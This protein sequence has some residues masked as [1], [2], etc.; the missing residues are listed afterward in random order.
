MERQEIVNKL[1]EIFRQ[2]FEN[3][4]LVLEESM[5][6]D[7]VDNWASLTHM[8][9]A[10]AVQEEFGITFSIMDQI[11]LMRVGDIISLIESKTA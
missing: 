6:P 3:E 7:D 5:T 4:N 8:Q 1:T 10:N 2:V 9:M 11:K